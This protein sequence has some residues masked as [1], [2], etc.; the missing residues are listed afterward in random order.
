MFHEVMGP[1]EGDINAGRVVMGIRYE[2]RGVPGTRFVCMV[3][4]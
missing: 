2:Q 1:H 3:D 4:P